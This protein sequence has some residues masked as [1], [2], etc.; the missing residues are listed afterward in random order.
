MPD[1]IRVRLF[2]ELCMIYDMI[3]DQAEQLKLKQPIRYFTSSSDIT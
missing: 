2:V 1:Y 3:G